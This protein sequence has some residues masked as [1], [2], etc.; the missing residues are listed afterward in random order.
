M[1]DVAV[2]KYE[3]PLKSLRKAIKLCDGF[4][5]LKNDTRVYIK[6]NLVLWHEGID[7]PK[8]G[9]L[10]TARMIEDCVVLLKEHGVEEI[11]IIEG[12]VEI[13]KNGPSLVMQAAAGMGFDKLEK[14]YGVKVVDVLRAPST[15]V[16]VDDV[17]LSVN[18]EI[19]SAD[20]IVNLP[21]FKTHSQAKI[22]LG[23]KNL[24]GLINIKS[25]EECHNADRQRDLDYYMAKFIDMVSPSLTII[26]GI[27]SL[28]RGP[29]Y[30]GKA[31]R[32]DVIIASRDLI[33]ADLVGSTML[34]IA[35]DSVPYIRETATRRG[36]SCDLDKINL[37]GG[38]DIHNHL[39]PH[40]WKFP[41][42]ESKPLPAA[43]ERAGIEGVRYPDGD[44]SICTYC[45]IFINYVIMGLLMAKN[46]D[47]K[48]DDLEFLYG[49]IQEPEGGHKHTLLVGQCQV[50]KNAANPK[51]NHCVKIRGCPPRKDDF[52]KAY[53]EVGIELPDGFLEWM[54]RSPEL[55]HMK[56]YL[57]KPDFDPAFFA[58]D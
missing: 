24:K 46:P 50:K 35:P 52:L 16:T 13:E 25:R 14:R 49:K 33:S 9:M 43:F 48:F 8:Y 55:L 5:G 19:L 17:T 10:T 3:E 15:R 45:S 32:S 41:Y 21:V 6:P 20:F 28:E 38:I 37:L 54:E 29:F 27:Y 36:R 40:K 1:F 51:I 47:K 56:R 2:V 4:A 57:D 22:S 23:I 58:I 39:K 12:A 18:E 34:G 26:D 30:N 53:A 7:F 42:S 31:R 11:T 44:K